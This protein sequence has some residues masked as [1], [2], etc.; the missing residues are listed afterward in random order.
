MNEANHLQS[1]RGL[2]STVSTP[3]VAILLL[4]TRWKALDKIYKIYILSHHKDLKKL[5]EVRSSRLLIQNY[6]ALKS[7][8]TSVCH[9]YNQWWLNFIE[10]CDNTSNQK[11][12]T[13]WMF[14]KLLPMFA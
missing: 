5:T 2:F 13:L 14:A 11:M 12:K 4:S 8:F 7:M 3:T 10:F 1:L 6:V 9:L